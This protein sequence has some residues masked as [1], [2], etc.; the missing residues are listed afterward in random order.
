VLLNLFSV[1]RSEESSNML[2]KI[3][4]LGQEITNNLSDLLVAIFAIK[5]S[6]GLLKAR[7]CKKC[8]RVFSKKTHEGRVK[9]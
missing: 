9:L 4:D 1:E 7:L 5:G 3:S 8:P 6:Y 2:V